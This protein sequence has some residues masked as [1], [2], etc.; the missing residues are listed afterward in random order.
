MIKYKLTE[1]VD[2]MSEKSSDTLPQ[3]Q[4]TDELFIGST[5]GLPG[6]IG[7]NIENGTSGG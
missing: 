6:V 4:Q 7:T 5:F 1:I 2:S 3:N